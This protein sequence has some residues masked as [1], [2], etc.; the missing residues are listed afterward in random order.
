LLYCVLS[1]IIIL[2]EKLKRFGFVH[3]N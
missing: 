3:E 1:F 2:K